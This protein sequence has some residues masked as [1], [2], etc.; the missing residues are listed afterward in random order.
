VCFGPPGQRNRG[1]GGTKVATNSL[2]QRLD[3]AARLAQSTIAGG[4][5]QNKGPQ[6]ILNGTPRGTDIEAIRKT[7]LLG[8]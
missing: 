1:P 7:T 2:G 6:T 3:H 8:V 5:A 4:T